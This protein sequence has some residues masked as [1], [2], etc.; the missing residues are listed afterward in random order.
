MIRIHSSSHQM[1]SVS[2]NYKLLFYND[3]V[4]LSMLSTV[5]AIIETF[6]TAGLE[7]NA[8]KTK[9]L[10]VTRRKESPSI[11]LSANGTYIIIIQS[12]LYLGVTLS[13]DLSFSVHIHNVCL[14]AKSQPRLLHRL[15]HK[16]SPTACFK[17]AVYKSLVFPIL[18]YTVP[19]CGTLAMRSRSND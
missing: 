5:L 3:C 14:K 15:F 16:A 10:V 6:S 4:V 2:I 9:L 8:S 17:S 19:L 13:K 7:L 1:T 12:V 11:Q 18:D